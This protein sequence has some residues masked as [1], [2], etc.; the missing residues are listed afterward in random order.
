MFYK[1]IEEYDHELKEMELELEETK[2]YVKKHPEKLGTRGNYETMK[3]L[4]KVFKEDKIEFINNITN[5]NLN[6]QGESLIQPLSTMN[7][8]ILNTKFNK[9]TNLTMNL[10]EN[11]ICSPEE[12]LNKSISQ[13]SYKITFAFPNPTEEDVKRTS[14][15]KKGLMKIF[16]FINC[17]DDIEKLKK[18]KQDPMVVKLFY[19]IKSF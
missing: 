14:P 10:L 17:G 4:Y 2:E 18:K 15:R 11:K 8:N 7:L 12:F 19:H 5:F 13:G 9:T 3:Y 16:D 1:T 6:L